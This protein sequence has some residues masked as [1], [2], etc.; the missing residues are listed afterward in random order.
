MKKSEIFQIILQ[1][2]CVEVAP[3]DIFSGCR[4]EDVVTAKSIIVAICK[5][6]GFRNYQLQDLLRYKSHNAIK[7][8]AN[9]YRQRIG[10][11]T[12]FRNLADSAQKEL[13]K[14]R[15]ELGQK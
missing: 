5:K 3:A 10:T 15:A 8:L 11:D 13:T 14:A 12:G 2:E 4:K 1:V 6:R 9:V 7:H